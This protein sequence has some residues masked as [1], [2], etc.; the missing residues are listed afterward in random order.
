LRRK[1]K[2][3]ENHRGE[4]YLEALFEEHIAKEFVH[5][6]VDATIAIHLSL[7]KKIG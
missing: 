2:P 1:T 4:R 6:D 5:H 3:S 7:M